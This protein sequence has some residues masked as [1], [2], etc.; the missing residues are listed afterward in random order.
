MA[1]L[2]PVLL[3]TRPAEPFSEAVQSIQ[4]QTEVNT[5]PTP[6]GDIDAQDPLNTA[7]SVK[8]FSLVT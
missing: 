3:L 1:P 4:V 2:A 6:D 5:S 8:T 7:H